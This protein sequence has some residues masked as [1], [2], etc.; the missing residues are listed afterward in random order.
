M[1]T[2]GRKKGKSS[3]K[4][5][6]SIQIALFINYIHVKKETLT[7]DPVYYCFRW[8]HTQRKPSY[9]GD[10]GT[11]R[12]IKAAVKEE[13]NHYRSA[14]R[15]GWWKIA[16]TP[17]QSNRSTFTSLGPHSTNRPTTSF[18]SNCNPGKPWDH[19]GGGYGQPS[20]GEIGGQIYVP[21]QW[22]RLRAEV[23]STVWERNRQ[24]SDLPF[25][26]WCSVW[27][28]SIGIVAAGTRWMVDRVRSMEV[29]EKTMGRRKDEVEA[30]MEDTRE[31]IRTTPLSKRTTIFIWF[32]FAFFVI[33]LFLWYRLRFLLSLSG[34]WRKSLLLSFTSIVFVT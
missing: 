6:V 26:W 11:A 13:T 19:P 9:Q 4:S 30:D 1:K 14:V 31:R 18:R 28:T 24:R 10:W 34:L 12:P 17:I 32:L 15:T 5:F 23:G 8:A 33:L 27:A 25:H 21:L 3:A 2:D 20:F 7:E 22:D 29:A 16:A